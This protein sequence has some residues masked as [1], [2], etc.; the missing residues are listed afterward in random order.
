MTAPL[1]R[2]EAVQH[3]TR[4]L[5]GDVVIISP[6]S[7][8]VFG[9]LL[10]LIVGAAT[11][12]ASTAQY[13]R[14]EVV[15]G[16]LVPDTGAVRARALR[17]GV[18]AELLVEPGDTVLADQPI[19]R[20]DLSVATRTG[21]LA[22][23]LRGSLETLKIASD[24]QWAAT[25]Q[26]L[27]AEQSRLETRRTNARLQSAALAVQIQ[28]A[29]ERLAEADETAAWAA[30]NLEDGLTTRSDAENWEIAARNARQ[31]LLRL[32]QSEIQ[33]QSEIS[34][35]EQQVAAIAPDI[36]AALATYET[37]QA[38]LS[39]RLVRADAETEYVLTS[40]ISG[41]V[42]ALSI[43]LGQTV[44]TG[45]AVA[46]LTPADSTLIAELFL[47]SRSSSFI[48]PGQTVRLKYDAFPFQR[49]GAGR[50]EVMSVSR[51][52]LSASEIPFPGALPDQPVFR[53][54]V[55]LENEDISAY[56][57]L[58]PLRPGLLL[59]ADVIFDRRSLI[60]WLL[61]PIYAVGSK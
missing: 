43:D 21:D 10:A 41:R 44:S 5:G 45:A 12:F 29:Q 22:Q 26:R 46:V 47:P 8:W 58:I 24:A 3:A 39:E 20:I 28:E 59:S 37:V 61:D 49:F 36:E 56:G 32:Q 33:L 4:R 23:S 34:D 19:A 9:G 1:F 16:W 15:A 6:L 13:A 35:I 50:G 57:E 55:K 14:K 11:V 2:P 25:Q 60:E 51:T 42:E 27:K 7:V 31:D 18:V 38:E 40:P 30:E 48:K 52:I 17:G 54:R 53:V